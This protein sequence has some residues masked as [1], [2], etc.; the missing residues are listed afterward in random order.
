MRSMLHS[1]LFISWACNGPRR[2]AEEEKKRERHW[3]YARISMC[4][5]PYMSLM[6]D[7]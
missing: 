5:V 2:E 1:S 3:W 7:H 4:L 6:A